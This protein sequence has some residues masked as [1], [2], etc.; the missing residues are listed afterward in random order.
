ML[1]EM[2]W[3]LANQ[4]P[5]RFLPSM[6]TT[7]LLIVIIGLAAFRAYSQQPDKPL[8]IASVV[9]LDLVRGVV[10]DN[11][12]IPYDLP[13]RFTG[14][15]PDDADSALGMASLNELYMFYKLGGCKSS[16]KDRQAGKLSSQYTYVDMWS[17]KAKTMFGT[18]STIEFLFAGF[19]PDYSLIHQ[20]FLVHDQQYC[21]AIRRTKDKDVP[22]YDQQFISIRTPSTFADH[23]KLD[24]GLG[25]A[26]KP[27]AIVGSVSLH[28]YL[29]PINESTDL[30]SLLSPWQQFKRRAS[31]FV[32]LVPLTI[33]SWSKQ[34]VKQAANIGNVGFGIGYRA[35]LYG[36][37]WNSHCRRFLQ[38][39]RL[40]VGLMYFAQ[41]DA[42]PVIPQDRYKWSPFASITFDF[43][44]AAIFGPVAKLFGSL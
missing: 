17:R 27:Q 41:A 36:P 14:S 7:Q 8:P 30:G 33:H 43:S 15:L 21:L 39:M 10:V 32:C 38:P 6:K 3:Q 23:F 31:L 1:S 12:P 35:P 18:P 13:L 40:N 25:Y 34:D 37:H 29:N 20:E 26:F 19:D 9:E 24:F 4:L 11:A 42:N 5:G 28:A 2:E 16:D 22:E 44:I